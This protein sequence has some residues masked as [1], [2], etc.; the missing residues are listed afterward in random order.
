MPL[1]NSNYFP[2]PVEN[3]IMAVSYK[4]SQ[5]NSIQLVNL[6]RIEFQEVSMANCKFS[7]TEG[8]GHAFFN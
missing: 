7:D 1:K 3:Q 4:N 6:I 2:C 8:E 5:L